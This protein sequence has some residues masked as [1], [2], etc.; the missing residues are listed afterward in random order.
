MAKKIISHD[1]LIAINKE[2]FSIRLFDG[3]WRGKK[4]R[5]LLRDTANTV[6]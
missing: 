2:A 6:W 3:L 1:E 4:Y 5:K